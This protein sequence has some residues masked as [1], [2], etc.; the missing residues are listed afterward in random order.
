MPRHRKKVCRVC[1]RVY[2]R[3]HVRT[4]PTLGWCGPVCYRKSY[5]RRKKGKAAGEAPDPVDD[6]AIQDPRVME[7]L[8]EVLR[9]ESM[10]E[11]TI[12]GEVETEDT[13]ETGAMVIEVVADRAL[14]AQTRLGEDDR[15]EVE[16]VGRCWALLTEGEAPSLVD[17]WSGTVRSPSIW[18]LARCGA[19]GRRS[20]PSRR[21]RVR[22]TGWKYG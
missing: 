7:A 8:A 10:E 16:W 18:S 22:P 14:V 19:S 15:V 17:W 1:G 12:A 20:G 2:V 9:E 4:N 6:S 5:F 3:R 21:P 11:G 13:I